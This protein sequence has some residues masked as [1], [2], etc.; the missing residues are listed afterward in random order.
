MGGSLASPPMGEDQIIKIPFLWL[1]ELESIGKS[2]DDNFDG[3]ISFD[4]FLNGAKHCSKCRILSLH[5][6]PLTS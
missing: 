1:Q 5:D 6:V 3:E 2:I 4:E